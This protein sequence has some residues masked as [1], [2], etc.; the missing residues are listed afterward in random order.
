M[1]LRATKQRTAIRDAFTDASRPLGPGEVHE[2]AKQQVPRLGMATVYRALNELVAEGELRTVDLPGRV[3]RYEKADLGHHHHFHCT[4]CDRVY[5]LE[6]CMLKSDLELPEG[7][8]VDHHDITL[9]G[10]CPDCRED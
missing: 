1:P 5:D 8:K 4:D 6:G 7:F 10:T 2:I 3:S 9:S